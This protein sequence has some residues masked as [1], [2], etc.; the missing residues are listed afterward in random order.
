MNKR[1]NMYSEIRKQVSYFLAKVKILMTISIL[2]VIK[3]MNRSPDKSN[4]KRTFGI[5]SEIILKDIRELEKFA[6]ENHLI[7]D[8]EDFRNDIRD[9]NDKLFE[10]MKAIGA[11]E[12][13]DIRKQISIAIGSIKLVR[14]YAETTNQLDKQWFLD[15]L[16][17]I[18]E[19]SIDP[20]RK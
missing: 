19:L 14:K 4:P 3:T 15:F 6:L 16:D 1:L 10:A 8:Y 9:M 11:I 7:E 2:K 18:N 20:D 13:Y 5:Y 17:T 12:D